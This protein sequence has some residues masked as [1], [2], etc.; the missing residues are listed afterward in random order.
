MKRKSFKYVSSVLVL[1]LA[2]GMVMTGCGK[3]APVEEDVV[4]TISISSEDLAP[5][6]TDED[7]GIVRKDVSELMTITGYQS[8]EGYN[9][10]VMT[11]NV[12]EA[13]SVT[14]QVEDEDLFNS[15]YQ[16]RLFV[17]VEPSYSSVSQDDPM[18]SA[19]AKGLR[20][21]GED[22][23]NISTEDVITMDDQEEAPDNEE[24][25]TDDANVTDNVDNTDNTDSTEDVDDLLDE[26]DDT[27]EE[28]DT[29]VTEEV[30]NNVSD[31]DV[32]DIESLLNGGWA[33]TAE[34]KAEKQA[35]EDL[36]NAIKEYMQSV[37]L[38]RAN[39]IL[40]YSLDG[41]LLGEMTPAKLNDYVAAFD[42][43]P[44]QYET[45]DGVVY[46]SD[47]DDGVEYEIPGYVSDDLGNCEYM[48]KNDSKK[49]VTLY[50]H[51]ETNENEEVIFQNYM[52]TKQSTGWYLVE[53]QYGFVSTDPSYV[54]RV[55]HM[56]SDADLA[57]SLSEKSVLT[58]DKLED[59][60]VT[61]DSTY[62]AIVNNTDYSVYIQA[63]TGDSYIL[64]S[65]QAIGVHK[66]AYSSLTYEFEG[67]GSAE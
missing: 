39:Q 41:E 1:S 7:L 65:K 31:E 55:E 66:S 52:P 36:N 14:I 40:I 24:V 59:K 62:S 26:S 11:P 5:E 43:A 61:V 63:D 58:I 57:A 47:L 50:L 2:L 33:D 23:Y 48:I 51:S 35:Q 16:A 37:S 17:Y 53:N 27:S 64:D 46:I 30:F 6:I 42:N 38:N 45:K 56:N 13:K 60:P 20:S 19:Y 18:Y 49:P 15:L 10:L 28:I 12:E 22:F 29:N 34:A 9:F 21:L 54:L 8:W 67:A 4:T 44:V 25:S 3:K 32:Q